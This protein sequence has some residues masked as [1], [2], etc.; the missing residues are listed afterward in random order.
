MLGKLKQYF[1]V[2]LWSIAFQVLFLLI[3][4]R[5]VDYVPGQLLTYPLAI[6]IACVIA[7]ARNTSWGHIIVGV[8]VAYVLAVVVR[9]S[10]LE[11]PY[12]NY[13]LGVALAP[14]LVPL[15]LSIMGFLPAVRHETI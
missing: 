8:L 11:T 6:C 3:L 5:P 9:L 12:W 4:S 2:V 7:T 14:F 13:D 1:R 15:L 10:W